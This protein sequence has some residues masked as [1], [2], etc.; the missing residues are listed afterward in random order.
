MLSVGAAAVAVVVRP[1]E[2]SVFRNVSFHDELV[3]GSLSSDLM[4]EIVE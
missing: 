3:G 2:D 1:N 4:G